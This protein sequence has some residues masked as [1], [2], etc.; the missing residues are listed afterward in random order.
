[1]TYTNVTIA[2][3][4]QIFKVTVKLDSSNTSTG[5][6]VTA[7]KAYIANGTVTVTATVKHTSG[8]TFSVTAS[9]THT[10]TATYTGASSTVSVVSGTADIS[11]SFTAI[12]TDTVVTIKLA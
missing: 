3:P 9:N 12:S 10:G 1:M 4:T 7:D 5:W 6:S 11:L 8:G 2:A